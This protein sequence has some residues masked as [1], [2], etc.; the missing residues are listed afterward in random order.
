MMKLKALLILLL[1]AL[2]LSVFAAQDEDPWEGFNRASLNFNFV[3]DRYLLRPIAQ[4]YQTVVPGFARKGANNFFANLGDV[5]NGVN[6]LL[7]GKPVSAVSDLGRI[8][9]NT[10]LGLGGLFDPASGIGM[11]KHN[12]S[13]GQTLS[14]WG[15]PQGPFVVLP[16]LGPSTAMDTAARPFDSALDPL[17]Y[18]YPVDHRNRLLGLRL[19]DERTGLFTAAYNVSGDP[20]VFLR[21]AYLQRRAELV[22]D[23]I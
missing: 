13:F 15:V 2:P 1:T 23:Q 21:N 11:K 16:L 3:A 6:N 20:Y 17:R 18:L 7:Q 19:I 8:V 4:T 9:V 10:T 12:E 22:N 14:V 5:N